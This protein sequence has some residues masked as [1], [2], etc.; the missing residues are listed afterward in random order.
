MASGRGRTTEKD[1]SKGGREAREIGERETQET[2]SDQVDNFL[3]SKDMSLHGF[4]TCLYIV[5]LLNNRAQL[6]VTLF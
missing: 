2:G 1:N 5:Y 6:S 4:R 3:I